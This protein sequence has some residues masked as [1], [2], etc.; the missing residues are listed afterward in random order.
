MMYS[1]FIYLMAYL[2]KRACLMD[3]EMFEQLTSCKIG[4]IKS[5]SGE[6]PWVHFPCVT[7]RLTVKL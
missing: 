2:P 1:Q 4:E 6:W 5:L 3:V 7:C